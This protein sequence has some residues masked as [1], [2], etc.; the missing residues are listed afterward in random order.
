MFQRNNT[1]KPQK[2]MRV[3]VT[4][5][6]SNIY[7]GKQGGTK[8][9]RGHTKG[10]KKQEKIH[11]PIY[12]STIEKSLRKKTQETCKLVAPGWNARRVEDRGRKKD[13]HHVIFC[14]FLALN[15]VNVLPK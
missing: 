12:L 13:L 3:V 8:C 9:K 2:R 14:I 6:L 1:M 11:I 5:T 7:T 15:F 10:K 4:V